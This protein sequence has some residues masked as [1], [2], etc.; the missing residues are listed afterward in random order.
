MRQINYYLTLHEVV[1][2]VRLTTDTVI[3]LVGHGI[4]QPSGERPQE[5]LF[6]PAMLGTLRRAARLQQDLELDWEAIALALVLIDQIQDLRED[7][8]R[9]RQQLRLLNRSE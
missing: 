6:E 4:V 1:Q 5:W 7:N 2:S 3:T 9:L 8:S